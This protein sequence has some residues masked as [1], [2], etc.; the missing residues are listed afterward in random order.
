MDASR[1]RTEAE[2]DGGLNAWLW[3]LLG[4]PTGVAAIWGI[5]WLDQAT[6]EWRWKRKQLRENELRPEIWPLKFRIDSFTVTHEYNRDYGSR[7]VAVAQ[8]KDGVTAKYPQTMSGK[9][10]QIRHTG[11]GDH[12]MDAIRE[13]LLG[14][15][16]DEG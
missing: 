12:P 5:A 15:K 4:I 7:W 11:Y 3:F 1:E 14:M 6:R 10:Y 9:A 16:E 2:G 8:D 13:L